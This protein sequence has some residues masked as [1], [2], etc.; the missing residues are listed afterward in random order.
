[1]A[2]QSIKKNYAYNV[3]F[4]IF[5]ILAPLITMPYVARVLEADFIGYYSYANSI[6]TY[7]ALF[8]SLGIASYGLREVSLCRN[9]KQRCS[10]IFRELST[11]RFMTTAAFA[12]AF[13]IA[14]IINGVNIDV[15]L[16][17]GIILIAVAFDFT[18][19]LQAMEEFKTLMLRNFVIKLISIVCIF[20][21]V[22]EKEDLPIYI[23]IQ[24]GSALLANLLIIPSVKKHL[25]PV[26]KRDLCYSQHFRQI[27]IYFVP[28]IASSVY[29]VLD[30]TMLGVLTRSTLENGYY[31]QAH[32]VINVMLAVITS[33]NV[34]VGV[35]TTYLFGQ[36]DD[37]RVKKY[38]KKTFKFMSLV[39]MPM[40]FGLVACAR[41]FVPLFFGEGY[42]KVAP[43][44]MMFS[45]LV[46][47]IGIS[48]IIGTLYLTPSG[49]RAKA[50]RV[51][52]VGAA[53]NFILNLILIPT[54]KSYG[55]VAASLAA[56]GVI[57]LLYIQ[58]MHR[59]LTVWD[60]FKAAIKYVAIAFVMLVVVQTI[61]LR[62]HSMGALLTQVS[63]GAAIYIIGLLV[64][65]D[66]IVFEEIKKLKDVIN[67]RRAQK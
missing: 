6:T 48:N 42:D 24:M 13:V 59:Y 43:V 55:A 32:K 51:I 56:E 61:G 30:R 57:S 54:F 25:V 14:V 21:F 28:A 52:I 12:V 33:L 23:M 11:I 2:E 66:E 4:Q 36:G 31:E 63:V 44:L 49:Q 15:Y 16:A 1:M 60:V 39:S 3:V 19:F 65:R 35:R 50:N 29:T 9:D 27:L 10:E 41:N 34:I 38:I 7:F 45:P 18:W 8:S 64:T 46:F 47:I 17:C 22:K 5:S 58:L 67:K 20:I 40:I 53:V 26:N 62:W 37:E